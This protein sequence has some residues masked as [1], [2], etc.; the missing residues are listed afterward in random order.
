[1]SVRLAGLTV[2][3]PARVA[4]AHLQSRNLLSSSYH[5]CAQNHR[6]QSEGSVWYPPTLSDRQGSAEI[7]ALTVPVRSEA[8]PRNS[9][10]LPTFFLICSCPSCTIATPVGR[11]HEQVVYAS[12]G[13]AAAPAMKRTSSCYRS[14][15]GQLVQGGTCGVI[16]TVFEPRE[17]R[18]ENCSCLL[19]SEVRCNAAH[20]ERCP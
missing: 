17:P 3:C 4:D 10:T 9:F 2:R 20:R 5:R 14:R 19:R 11:V 6:H 13:E 18:P 12:T 8:T 16:A 7:S 1:M 15:E